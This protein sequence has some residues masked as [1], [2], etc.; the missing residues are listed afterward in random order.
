MVVQNGKVHLG[1]TR[2]NGDQNDRTALAR[3]PDGL[4]HRHV[5]AGA[6]V[7]DVRLVRAEGGDERRAEIGLPRIHAVIDAALFRLFEAQ[8]ADVCDQHTFSTHPLGS[9]RNE[10]ADR[11]RAEHRNAHAFDVAEFPHGVDGDGKRLDH[12]ALVEAHLLRQQRDLFGGDREVFRGD[13]RCLKAHDLQGFAE[14]VFPVTAGIAFSADDLRL[15]RDLLPDF[16]ALD[17]CAERRNFARNLVPLRDGIARERV[18]AV[19]DV[20]IRPA[21]ADLHDPHKNLAGLRRRRFD[22]PELNLPGRRHNLLQHTASSSK[23]KVAYLPSGQVYHNLPRKTSAYVVFA[24]HQISLLFAQCRILRAARTSTKQ[25]HSAHM[26][27][28]SWSHAVHF[29]SRSR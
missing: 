25:P 10:D 18:L 22:F 5:V 2:K 16:K 23:I 29:P 3:I 17:I 1:H 7:N 12:R 9:L 19:P 13:T 24:I 26:P 20:D 8:C 4:P 21:D 15:D 14:I 27:L 28:T 6:V 11:P